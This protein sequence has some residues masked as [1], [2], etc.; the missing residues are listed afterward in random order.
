MPRKHLVQAAQAQRKPS[1]RWATEQLEW[2]VD[3][4]WP[5]PEHLLP[6]GKNKHFLPGER[7]PLYSSFSRD[8]VYRA[9]ELPA[10]PCGPKQPTPALTSTQQTRTMRSSAAT[11]H[12]PLVHDPLAVSYV[13]RSVPSPNK[14]SAA[15]LPHSPA[16]AR[17]STRPDSRFDEDKPWRRRHPT[18]DEQ[19]PGMI[20]V[21][22]PDL[23]ASLLQQEAGPARLPGPASPATDPHQPPPPLSSQTTRSD[24]RP[25]ATA[26]ST[27]KPSAAP[28]A[29]ARDRTGFKSVSQATHQPFAVQG[30]VSAPRVV[31]NKY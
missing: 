21:A 25:P 19:T 15:P 5:N 17:R 26:P 23:L 13:A 16:P 29:P 7:E 31:L 1:K 30:S 10:V 12:S 4:A 20:T 6:N 9:Q 18:P 27:R 24:A 2:K 11:T 8:G 3:P 22:S 14:H 28:P